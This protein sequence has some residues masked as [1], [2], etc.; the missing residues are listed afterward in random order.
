[1]GDWLGTGTVATINRTY[2]PFEEARAIV[3]TL[4]L[5]NGA[6]WSSWA[7]SNAKPEGI[8]AEPA[9]VYKNAG[10]SAWGDWLGTGVIA[11]QN[12]VYLPFEEA[13]AI[14]RKLDLKNKDKWSSWAKSDAKPDNIPASPR[15][16][17]A[18]EG[19]AG[20]GDWLG[21]GTIASFNRTYLP[22]EEARAIVRRVGLR[23]QAEWLVWTK[24]DKRP[25]NI[26]AAPDRT[27]KNKGW[28]SIGDWLGTGVIAAR[29]RVYLPFEE[30]RA[31]VHA[32]SLKNQAEWIA[33]AKT[34]ARPHDIPANPA[35]VYKNAG[36]SGLGDWLGTGTIA[37]FNR[38]YLPFEEARAIVR[39][40]DLKNH[41]KWISWAKSDAKPDNIPAGPQGVY[42]GEGWAGIGDW[43]GVINRWNKNA[44]LGLL[45]DLRLVLH[46]L[47]ELDLYVVL[48]QG[49]AVPA[50]QIALNNTSRLGVL[51]DLKDNNGRELEKALRKVTDTELAAALAA[52][53]ADESVP[54]E[55]SLPTLSSAHIFELT[56]AGNAADRG[57]TPN[58][59]VAVARD[60]I[61]RLPQIVTP[62]QLRTL[63]RLAEFSCGLDEEAAEYLVGNHVSELW[64]TYHN[65]DRAAV[66]KLLVGDGGRWFTEIKHRFLSEV[67]A[68]ETLAVP[69][70]WSFTDDTGKPA[71]PNSMQMYTAWA[72]REK[73][74]IGNW[75]GVGSG[76]TLSAVLASRVVDARTTL[77][78]T[79]NATV[80]GWRRQIKQAYPDS[81]VL[82]RVD[83]GF[84]LARQRHNY[85]VLNYEK[86][87]TQGRNHLIHL[88]LGL[89]LDFIVFDEV[90]FV[91]QR[92]KKASQRRKALEAL[93]VAAA[94]REPQLRVLGMSA[95]PVIN[96]LLEA[97]KLLEIVAGMAFPEL[98]TPPTVDNA[99]KMHR[100]LMLHGFRYR[101]RYEQEIRTKIL[102]TPRNNLLES[103]RNTDNNILSIEQLLLPAKLDIS[104]DYF[105][106]GTLVYTDY[107]DELVAPVR[108]YIEAMDL[109]VGL[110]TGMDKSGLDGFLDGK[111][112]V[113]IGSRPVGTGLDG[114][115]KV[116]NRIV[117]LCLPWTGAAYEQI[118]GRIR[119]Q[120]SAFGEVE[121]IVPQV[122]LEYNGDTWSWDK[123]RMACIEYKR[124]LS[125]C[126]VDGYIPETVRISQNELLKQSREALERWIE[127][128]GRDG[129]LAIERQ[130]LTVPLPP[131]IRHKVQMRCGDFTVLNR[132]WNTSRGSTT[133]ERLEQDP[134][135][136]YLYHT[137]YREARERWPEQPYQRIA[138]RIRVRPDW[139]V[140][141]FGCGECPLAKALPNRVIG[142]DHVA[143]DESVI[144]CD[145]S[146][147]PLEDGSLDV[148]VFSLSLMGNNWVD[149]LK[150]AYRT[151]KPYGHIFIAEPKVR[152]QD[153]VHEL[154]EAI[155]ITGFHTLGDVEQRYDFI[156][157]TALKT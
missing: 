33:W 110:Y 61:N 94:E 3:H 69:A 112:D 13:R 148:A 143:L 62:E 125:D 99:L 146:S 28:L 81:V 133:H 83:D 134:S 60:A 80:Y 46:E 70:G 130:Q 12:R 121:V 64:E 111:V 113:L 41:A 11:N 129:I 95:T 109:K 34:D 100:S 37:V 78:V 22:F 115:Q 101:P 8:P 92:D 77:I 73:N 30:A 43:L 118:I 87:Q 29:N 56:N 48:Q 38:T 53:L 65:E 90:Q 71:L 144:A 131:D 76:K 128:I 44:L 27:Y 40:L 25:A 86:F 17:Y 124:T 137:L 96:N 156:Y 89:G 50:L 88:L 135:E 150:E 35:G 106:K 119:R 104:R 57:P 149:Y 107:V 154:K 141:D 85:V 103:L 66:D 142:L 39:K 52:D 20:F 36:W 51:R 139:V 1:L 114:L 102:E 151:L 82:T 126:A 132:R 26:P 75:S 9:V 6:E 157:L 123:G 91:K 155:S 140:G 136:W 19:W 68:V 97:K 31:F 93:V 74:R 147:V 2:L 138:E 21:T 116:C 42:G 152:W 67:D 145:M 45:N 122:T 10:W 120:G 23:N 7:K 47:K 108:R 84:T 79:N 63:D 24:S 58:T 127:R 32:L 153:R 59:E 14:V 49:G 55:G 18:G 4:G 15:S 16:I 98:N 105:R 117:M 5:K 54:N 72:V